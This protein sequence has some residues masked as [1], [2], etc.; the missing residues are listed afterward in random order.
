MADRF[1][2]EKMDDAA[3]LKRVAEALN[4]EEIGSALIEIAAN[5]CRAE[6]M[7]AALT[8]DVESS[9]CGHPPADYSPDL[10]W[11]AKR[12]Y[13]AAEAVERKIDELGLTNVPAGAA[14]MIAAA[15]EQARGSEQKELM[16][17]L[18][19]WYRAEHHGTS[20]ESAL[21]TELLLKAY[22]DFTDKQG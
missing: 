18:A 16:E 9:L 7:L 11:I 19:R 1:Y 22:A 12:L 2:R 20:E 13:L 14:E 21:Q 10:G 15:V 3:V 6:Q 8:R 17:A 4:T 5:A